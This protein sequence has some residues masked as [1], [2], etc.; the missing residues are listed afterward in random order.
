MRNQINRKYNSATSHSKAK[1]RCNDIDNDTDINKSL[2]GPADKRYKY[3][4][5]FGK[6]RNNNYNINIRGNNSMRWREMK[7]LTTMRFL[8]RV[9]ITEKMSSENLCISK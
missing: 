7:V 3:V 8:V 1:R 2:Q 5:T 9:M 6:F 4:L